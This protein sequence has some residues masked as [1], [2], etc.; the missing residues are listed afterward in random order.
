MVI[1]FPFKKILPQVKHLNLL[2]N[3]SGISSLSSMVN[4]G[5]SLLR[6]TIVSSKSSDCSTM[7][8]LSSQLTSNGSIRSNYSSLPSD[9]MWSYYKAIYCSQNL[10]STPKIET[11]KRGETA[12]ILR[13][14]FDSCSLS[15]VSWN[16]LSSCPN[17]GS[18]DKFSNVK[19]KKVKT[20]KS[21]VTSDSDTS[22]KLADLASFGSGSRS[23]IASFNNTDSLPL[24][25][26]G[27]SREEEVC[28][29]LIH[30][31]NKFISLMHRGVLRFSRPLSYGI[32][33]SS[34]HKTLFQNVEKLLAISEFHLKQLSDSWTKSKET[35]RLVGKIYRSQL[36]T[37]CESY[38]TYF[39]GLSAA[40]EQLTQLLQRTSFAHFLSQDLPDVPDIRLDT[41]LQAPQKHLQ[42]LMCTMDDIVC[43]ADPNLED[44][45]SLLDVQKGIDISLNEIISLDY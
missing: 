14:H 17:Q 21:S 33:S 18:F 3:M 19:G 13:N 23:N 22:L 34:E 45:Q 7:S 4:Q 32:L 15:S 31:E 12:D 44:F 30:A 26:R 1:T 43:V 28:L 40:D 42:D 16:E 27:T 20:G 8:T 29:H 11:P 10:N 37:L 25:P 9:S 24:F 36:S 2:A 38:L 6:R 5:C 35:I 41:F 39:L